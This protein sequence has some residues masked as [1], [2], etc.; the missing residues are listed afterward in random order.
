[1]PIETAASAATEPERDT[2]N[3]ATGSP[4]AMDV[5][6]DETLPAS[7]A[8]AAAATGVVQATAETTSADNAIAADSTAEETPT[9]AA[10]TSASG[11]AAAAEDT[12]AD[13]SITTAENTTTAAVVPPVW[14]I[15]A[16]VD[17]QHLRDLIDAMAPPAVR[18]KETQV[19]VQRGWV[20]G[21]KCYFEGGQVI[22]VKCY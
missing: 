16:S 8:Q 19:G 4:A 11:E 10:S 1:M 15:P 9:A 5:T 7:D 2:A 6:H 21:G 22:G 17:A 20:V 3:N 14:C 13:N 18:S 12:T